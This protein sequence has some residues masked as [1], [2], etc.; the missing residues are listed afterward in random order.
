MYLNVIDKATGETINKA[1][2][3]MSIVMPLTT[4]TVEITVNENV[5]NTEG[6]IIIQENEYEIKKYLLP[7]GILTLIVGLIVLG[8]LLKYISKTRS[9]EKMYEDELKKILFDYKSYIQKISNKVDYQ[10]YK[11][12]RIDTFKELLAMRE[13]IQSPI[14]MYTEEEYLKT[15]FIM[16]NGNIL[17]EN[18][19]EARLIREEL[20]KRS[21]EKEVK[22]R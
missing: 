22:N 1:N 9:A 10:D 6:K 15:T 18:I 8:N 2:K 3:V 20:I 21:K 12:I 4:K 19:L 5:K 13:E 7:I 17:F 11:I 16:I 14:L